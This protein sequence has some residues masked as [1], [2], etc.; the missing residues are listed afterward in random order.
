MLVRRVLPSPSPLWPDALALKYWNAVVCEFVPAGFHLTVRLAEKIHQAIEA[1]LATGKTI[2]EILVVQETT[3]ES[4]YSRPSGHYGRDWT[5]GD[6]MYE[7][8]KDCNHRSLSEASLNR[9]AR[10]RCGRAN[11][12]MQP[13]IGAH[14]FLPDE[15]CSRRRLR[16]IVKPFGSKECLK[17]WCPCHV[18]SMRYWSCADGVTFGSVPRVLSYA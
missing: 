1:A 16:L 11:T 9:P 2:A 15:R 6:E 18:K 10:F 12:T 4:V 3:E 14:R 7:G 5:A 8:E 17:S 13:T